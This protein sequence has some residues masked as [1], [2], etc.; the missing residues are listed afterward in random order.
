MPL[1]L[2]TLVRLLRGIY[3]IGLFLPA[4]FGIVPL[5]QL[6]KKLHIY[7]TVLG[8][9]FVDAMY[10]LPYTV[11]IMMGFFATIPKEYEEAAMSFWNESIN[12]FTRT[13]RYVCRPGG[14]S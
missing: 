12:G 7:D 5:F 3:L 9:S 10:F 1:F 13:A 4:I 8:L 2:E 6:M 14:P 11:F